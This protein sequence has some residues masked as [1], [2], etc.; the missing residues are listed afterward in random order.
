MLLMML[1]GKKQNVSKNVYQHFGLMFTKSLLYDCDCTVAFASGEARKLVLDI[2]KLGAQ[3]A[4][5]N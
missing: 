1:S 4:A 5:R 2:M 3:S